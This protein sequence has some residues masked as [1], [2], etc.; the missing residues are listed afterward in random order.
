MSTSYSRNDQ[1]ITASVS[2]KKSG[3]WKASEGIVQL[4]VNEKGIAKV[5]D[6]KMDAGLFLSSDTYLEKIF[7]SNPL[8]L[9]KYVG[10]Y[11]VLDEREEKPGPMTTTIFLTAD[12]KCSIVEPT[13]DEN[14][15]IGKPIKILS[16]WQANADVIKIVFKENGEDQL[17]QFD[18]KEGAFR[19]RNLL[20]L[21]KMP[22]PAPPNPYLK[23]YA[24][25]YQ[26]LTD[27]VPA[28]PEMDQYVFTQDGK[29]KWTL[30]SNVN[31]DGTISKTPVIKEGTWSAKEG[32]IHLT[33]VLGDFDM[34][35]TDLIADYTL[36]NGVFRNGS[37]FLKKMP[38]GSK[39]NK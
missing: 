28:S 20:Y 18:F 22:P 39:A 27:G 38:L 10:S 11:H 17:V 25:T 23:L 32:L 5:V 31:P 16:T 37:I 13:M 36:Q 26:M 4:I 19:S 15:V 6:F 1:G 21:K 30:F 12:G 34:S 7:I 8:F 24:G 35:S 3:T 29:C 9:K 2:M 14:G 33:F